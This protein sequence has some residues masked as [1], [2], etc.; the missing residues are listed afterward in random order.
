[1]VSRLYNGEEKERNKNPHLFCQSLSDK[2]ITFGG[3]LT[4]ITVVI[5]HSRLRFL[6]FQYLIHNHCFLSPP[7][8][9]H[10]SLLFPQ[11][12]IKNFPTIPISAEVG[13]KSLGSLSCFFVLLNFTTLG[14]FPQQYTIL[15]SIPSLE[16]WPAY[17]LSQDDGI[18]L[19]VKK[20][21]RE[22][23]EG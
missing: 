3:H 9:S 15:F 8:P 5:E 14:W 2:T 10:P 11:L 6:S 18:P 19:N 20:I 7:L 13:W 4:S 23:E 12:V 17:N 16:R 1:M 22:K 21:S